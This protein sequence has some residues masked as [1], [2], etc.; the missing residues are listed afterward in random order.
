MYQESMVEIAYRYL[1]DAH[2]PVSF[3]KIWDYVTTHLEY[4]EVQKTERI[5]LFYTELSLDGRF[6][7]LGENTW[8]LREHHTYDKVHIDM[9]DIYAEVEDISALDEDERVDFPLLDEVD[10]VDDEDEEEKEEDDEEE[11]Y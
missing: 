5:S 11:D 6:V 3:K 2:E 10:L 9:N 8:D 1:K 4:T 7:T